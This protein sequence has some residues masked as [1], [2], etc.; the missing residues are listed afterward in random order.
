VPLLLREASPA[1]SRGKG[2]RTRSACGAAKPP[3][4]PLD[5]AGLERF[6]ALKA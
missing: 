2:A 1:A 6:A 4:R 5:A 3:P